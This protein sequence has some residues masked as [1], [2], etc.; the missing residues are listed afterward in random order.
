MSCCSC[1][2]H[3][4]KI[5]PYFLPWHSSR[6]WFSDIN[7]VLSSTLAPLSI[8]L[9]CGD[10]TMCWVLYWRLGEF[11]RHLLSRNS[12]TVL[13]SVQRKYVCGTEG[14]QSHIPAS[15]PFELS[16]KG[17]GR[18]FNGRRVLRAFK[19]KLWR[20]LM[21]SVTQVK[22]DGEDKPKKLSRVRSWKALNTVLNNAEI[23]LKAEGNFCGG[24]SCDVIKWDVSFRQMTTNAFWRSSDI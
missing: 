3:A 6:P 14:S 7:F 22:E 20:S 18:N 19:A 9:S 17:Y 11:Y 1:S 15:L 13:I 12:P 23:F 4:G 10:C 8:C 2:T 21:S 24:L 16:P 5:L